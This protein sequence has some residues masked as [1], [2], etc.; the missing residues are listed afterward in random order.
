MGDLRSL[1]RQ[2]H[3]AGERR[4][5]NASMTSMSIRETAPSQSKTEFHQVLS[6]LP[7]GG[8]SVTHRL[9]AGYYH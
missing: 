2:P 1:L 4:E 7:P 8:L 3:C 6:R 9:R 5:G